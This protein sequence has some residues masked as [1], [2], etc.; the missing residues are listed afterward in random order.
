MIGLAMVTAL[1]DGVGTILEKLKSTGLYNNS[2][3]VFSSD[4]RQSER[5]N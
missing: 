5:Q 4:V 3:I 2:V 1:D